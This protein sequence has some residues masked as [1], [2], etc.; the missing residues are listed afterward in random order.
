[1]VAY[2][3]FSDQLYTF[4]DRILTEMDF[5]ES[6]RLKGMLEIW[7]QKQIWILSLG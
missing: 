6:L 1:M 5:A 4:L 7:K 2:H 3:T